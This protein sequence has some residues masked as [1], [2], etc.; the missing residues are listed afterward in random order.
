MTRSTRSPRS[1]SRRRHGLT[2]EAARGVVTLTLDRPA[3]SNRVDIGLAQALCAA[4]ETIEHDESVRV[5][6]LRAS[7]KDFCLGADSDVQA[8]GWVEAIA[9]LTRPVVAVV[10]GAAIGEG[11]EL[12]LACDIRLASSRAHFAMPQMLAG[13]LPSCGGTQRLPRLIGATRA[14]ELLLTGRR[15]D[16]K[17]ALAMGLISH[18]VPYAR[19][20]TA[21]DALVAELAARG[22]LAL[23]YAKEAVWKGVDMT[24]EQGI[25]LEQDLYVLLQ[26]TAD[27][28]EGIRAFQRKRAP[29]FRG[30]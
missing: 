17:E 12:A 23:R 2:V 10:Q 24:L 7:G 11:L 19:L 28:A 30:A 16:A 25:R 3:L 18:L 5:V 9:S 6:V 13:R 26:T 4:A 15:I 21:A 27:R 8:I 14:L 22:P 20:T 1:A 29:R